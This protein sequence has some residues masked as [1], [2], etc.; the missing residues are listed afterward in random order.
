MNDGRLVVNFVALEQAHGDIANAVSTL[1]ESLSDLQRV[2][3]PLVA[4]WAGSAQEA[5]NQRQQTWTDASDRLTET[6]HSIGRAV[7]ASSQ[8]YLDT[9]KKATSLFQ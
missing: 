7:R 1:K 5:Y 2:A 8:D 9:E 6:L 3:Q 4:N